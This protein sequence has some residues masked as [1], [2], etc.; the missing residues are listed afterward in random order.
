M[1]ISNPVVTKLPSSKFWFW[2]ED[3]P[4][5]VK[6][7]DVKR[8]ICEHFNITGGELLS[9]QRNHDLVHARQLGMYLARVL[10]KR[11]FLEIGRR[12]ERDH[13]TIQSACRKI[14][15]LIKTDKAV[16]YE[17]AQIREKLL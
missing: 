1:L 9:P 11:S 16:V 7:E 4:G 8:V 12:F 17:L 3:S 5:P 6:I 10:S 14:S 15:H 13:A 2:I